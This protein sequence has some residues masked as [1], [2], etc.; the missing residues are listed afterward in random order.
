MTKIK[1]YQKVEGFRPS[2]VL[3]ISSKGLHDAF[4]EFGKSMS[5]I[6]KLLLAGIDAGMNEV[7]RK[8][9]YKKAKDGLNNLKYLSEKGRLMVDGVNWLER[10]LEAFY[11]FCKGVGIGQV[12]GALLQMEMGSGCQTIVTQDLRTGEIRT[13]HAE[14]DP[15]FSATARKPYGYRWVDMALPDKEISFFAYP[16]ICGWGPAFGVNKTTGLVQEIDD[17][18]PRKEYGRGILWSNA[19]AFMTLDCGEISKIEKLVKI[20]DDLPQGK[21]NGGYAIQL[22]QAG[23]EPEIM[24]VEFSGD[25]I[26]MVEPDRVKGMLYITQVNCPRDREIKVMSEGYYPPA[27]EKWKLDSAEFYVEMRN[28]KRRLNLLVKDTRWLG[29]SARQTI[30]LGLRMLAHPELDIQRTYNSAGNEVR[31]YTGLPS[32][33]TVAHMVAYIKKATIYMYVGKLTPKPIRGKE[34]AIKYQKDYRFHGRK[35]W[36]DAARAIAWHK[37]RK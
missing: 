7:T 27:G 26:K 35:L 20:A 37:K 17:L 5:K 21:F 28:R 12:Q 36:E 2:E 16:G 3:N 31:W 23:E 33:W 1:V 34:Y 14:E 11:G 19:M 25:K 29:K 30:S 24:S 15:W 6:D 22:S 9:E 4:V 10:Y 32:K 13:A 18:V 8:K